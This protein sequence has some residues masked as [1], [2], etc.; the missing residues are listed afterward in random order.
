MKVVNVG[1]C[2]VIS[3]LPVLTN[4]LTCSVRA[5][6]LHLFA[7]YV[8]SVY[9][10]RESYLIGDFSWVSLDPES[11]W[12]IW[13]H[14]HPKLPVWGLVLARSTKTPSSPALQANTPTCADERAGPPIT[15]R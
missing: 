10:V 8:G 7:L 1:D 2:I 6:C 13:S 3:V 5:A 14:N 9:G 11:W 4:K 12:P 15:I